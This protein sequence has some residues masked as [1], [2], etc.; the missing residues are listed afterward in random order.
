MHLWTACL[1]CLFRPRQKSEP[2]GLVSKCRLHAPDL[3]SGA[4]LHFNA[5]AL[6]RVPGH[7]ALSS[8]AEWLVPLAFEN[9]NGEGCKKSPQIP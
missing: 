5:I 7:V 6:G 2:L 9:P 1:S 3:K 8:G 4:A